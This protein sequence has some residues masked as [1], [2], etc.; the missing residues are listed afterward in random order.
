M[1]SIYA[2]LGVQFFRYV[3][4]DGVEGRY[5]GTFLRAM[6]T[7]FQVMTGES[8]AEGVARPIMETFPD[9]GQRVLVQM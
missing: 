6:L 1:T 9:N 4:L 2:I 8:W 7:M 5:F 3:V